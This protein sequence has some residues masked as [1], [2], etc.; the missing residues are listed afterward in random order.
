M[1]EKEIYDRNRMIEEFG[2]TPTEFIDVKGL[3]GRCF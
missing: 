3:N 1:S 2:V